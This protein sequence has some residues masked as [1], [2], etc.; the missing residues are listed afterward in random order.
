[1]ISDKGHEGRVLFIYLS[2]HI[3]SITIQRYKLQFAIRNGYIA[4]ACT[5]FGKMKFY[6]I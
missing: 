3:H 4:T 2:N 1:M 5:T 6:I